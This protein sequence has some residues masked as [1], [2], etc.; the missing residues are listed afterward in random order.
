MYIDNF[1][2]MMVSSKQEE[3][4]V[5]KVFLFVYGQ[6]VTLIARKKLDLDI[7]SF[8]VKLSYV[9]LCVAFSFT[10]YGTHR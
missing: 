5:I 1:I 7:C 3:E 6:V 8:C 10:A 4:V 9:Y 2:V